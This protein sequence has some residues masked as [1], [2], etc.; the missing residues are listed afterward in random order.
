MLRSFLAIMGIFLLASGTH[1]FAPTRFS[2]STHSSTVHHRV[3]QAKD[4]DYDDSINDRRGFLQTIPLVL[5]TMSSVLSVSPNA[6][7]A[8]TEEI[9]LPTRDTV[10]KSFDSIRYELQDANGGVSYMQSKI[11]EQDFVGLMEFTKTYDLELRK[12]RMGLAKKLLQDKEI[13]EKATEYANAV[14]FDLIGIN[15]SSRKGQESVESANKYLQEL[16][17]DVGKFLSLE[18]TIQ[19][20]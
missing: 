18:G 15:R 14:T 17:E 10:T 19:V 11:D 8:A 7:L 2:R 5:G 16:R 9:E 6:V 3:L 1:A 4:K 12:K 20:Q 13:K